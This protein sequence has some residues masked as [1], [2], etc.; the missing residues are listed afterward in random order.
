[1]KE[2]KPICAN[3]RYYVSIVKSEGRAFVCG[4]TASFMKWREVDSNFSCYRHEFIKENRK[5]NTCE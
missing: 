2:Y 1:M 4:N 3:C 5:Q